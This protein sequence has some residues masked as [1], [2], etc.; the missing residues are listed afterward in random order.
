MIDFGYW[1]ERGLSQ[2]PICLS[3]IIPSA[4]EMNRAR[5]RD[6]GMRQNAKVYFARRQSDGAIKIG[7]STYVPGRMCA[8]TRRDPVTLLLVIDGGFQVEALL[9]WCFASARVHGE[10]FLPIP[11]L[12]A[13][14]KE[15]R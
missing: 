9:H 3:P 15:S 7:T 13:Y 2:P 8:I 11:E 5:K 6:E 12:L 10:W 4:D 14:I 1:L